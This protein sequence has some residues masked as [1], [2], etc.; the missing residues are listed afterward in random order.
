MSITQKE[1]NQIALILDFALS[2]PDLTRASAESLFF[3]SLHFAHEI[4]NK[5]SAFALGQSFHQD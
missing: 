3:G 4:L 1:K 2:I 5:N